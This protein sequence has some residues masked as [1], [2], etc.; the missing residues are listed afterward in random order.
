MLNKNNIV[1]PYKKPCSSNCNNV[2]LL[3]TH[4]DSQDIKH[5]TGTV[6]SPELQSSTAFICSHGARPLFLASSG[7]HYHLPH[8]PEKTARSDA[9][10]CDVSSYFKKRT[11]SNTCCALP[12]D[13]YL[14][15]I[16]YRTQPI[17]YSPTITTIFL[18]PNE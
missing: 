18:N 15:K 10:T 14:C 2:A 8:R 12:K 9:V 13:K 16:I 5:K 1:A 7:P 6:P 11:A 3:G 4:N 17:Q